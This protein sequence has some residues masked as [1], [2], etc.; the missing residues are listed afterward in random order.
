[1]RWTRW[2]LIVAASLAT[3]I[4]LALSG[5][6]PAATGDNLRTITANQDGTACADANRTGDANG[7]IGTG[8]AFDG[9]NL[10]L[11]CWSDNT[12]VEVSPLDGSQVTIHQISGVS[13]LGALAWDNTD[14]Q[15]WACKDPPGA[16]VGTIDLVTNTFTT[17]FTSAGCTDGLAYD[18][19]DDTIWSSED[20]AP[21]IQHYQLDGTLISS[22]S[23][24]GEIGNSMNSGIAVGGA[25]L[26]L[27]NNG[28]QQ[29]YEVAKDFSTFSLFASFPRRLED[30]E[31]DNITFL[32][33]GKAAIW[34]NDAYDNILN[35]W[36]IPFGVCLFGGGPPAQITLSPK[37]A[38]NVVGNEHCVTATVTNAIGNPKKDIDVVFSVTGANS[39]GGTET[40][41]AAGTATSCY[42]GTVAGVDVITAFADANKNG[43]M[44][45]GEPS[46]TASKTWTP[47]P[48]ATL[49]LAPKT[50]TNVVDA[51]HCVTA[52]V[53]DQ[54]GNA[55]PAITVRF[56]VT[57]SVTT[58]GS[59]LTNG[60][61]Q[62][63]FCYQGP[64]LAGADV[65][66]A[67]ADTNTNS[68]Q[69]P[70]EPGDSAA[71]EWVLPPSTAGCKVTY[72]GRITAANTDKATFGGNAMVPASGA[73][74][75]EEYQD[76]G[77]VANLNVHSISIDVLAC[78]RDGASATIFGTATL[79]GSGSYAFRIDL[80]D[81][82]EPG[83]NDTY[84]IRL[85]TGYDSGT[86]TLNQ[87]NVQIHQ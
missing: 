25:L 72:G 31:C 80:Q 42:T 49:T 50:A 33:D 26:Y 79:N 1:M 74:G 58:S 53:K 44:D 12:I 86:Q 9:V 23:L 4:L 65:I 32:P 11:S 28:G 21:S 6:A 63:T 8:I 7:A 70:G 81:L 62:A 76:H 18:A 27:A 24:V 17:K 41:D 84:R 55:T 77:S 10:L 66:T 56:S 35:A 83:E 59:V 29:I 43:V 61:G 45:L 22:T 71:K 19:N 39:A 34:S 13:G 85:S 20:A 37:V 36:E 40:T 14:Q 47:G 48:P 30:L 60:S 46:D 5:T 15:L 3:T 73:Q 78:G 57:G 67:Y 82:G 38:T 68:V 75:Q 52:T 87:G 51:Q 54:Y 64:P 16:V 2:R 69:D